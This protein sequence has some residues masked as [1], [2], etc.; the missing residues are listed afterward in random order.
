M[1]WAVVTTRFDG[2]KITKVVALFVEVGDTV[3]IIEKV[4]MLITL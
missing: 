4:E 1:T 2:R 3:K